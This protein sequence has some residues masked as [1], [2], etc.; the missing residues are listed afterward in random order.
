ME[1]LTASLFFRG[2]RLSGTPGWTTK[3]SKRIAPIIPKSML[4]IIIL[5]WNIVTKSIAQ[6]NNILGHKCK[7]TQYKPCEDMDLF[8][9]H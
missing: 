9:F 2:T 1:R 4:M 6:L 5:L 8:S 7:K 3:T